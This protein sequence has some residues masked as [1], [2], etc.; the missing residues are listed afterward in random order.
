MT[1]SY[2]GQLAFFRVYSGYLESGS[3][4]LNAGRDRSYRIGRLLKMHANKKGRTSR[5]ST[6]A[7]SPPRWG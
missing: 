6:P 1:D 2:V 4:V 3:S 5:R 7:T